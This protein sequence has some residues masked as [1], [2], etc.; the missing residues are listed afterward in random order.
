MLG[1]V[2][3][4]YPS[5]WPRSVRSPRS[6]GSAAPRHCVSGTYYDARDRPASKRALRDEELKVHI[7][8]VHAENYGVYGPRKMWLNSTG[9]A[10]RWPGARSSG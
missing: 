9:R 8:R 5:Q 3:G 6:W 2:Q 10:S 1:E 4:E 7:V